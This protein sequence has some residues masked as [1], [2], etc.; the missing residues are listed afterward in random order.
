MNN[1]VFAC[2]MF[3]IVLAWALLSFGNGPVQALTVWALVFAAVSQ[4]S[5]QG[6][7]PTSH[8]VAWASI[9]VG[10]VMLLVAV[11]VF[12]VTLLGNPF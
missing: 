3:L 1:Y 11:I 9:A 8:R 5:A 7:S 6:E 10:M 2:T 4:F 12:T